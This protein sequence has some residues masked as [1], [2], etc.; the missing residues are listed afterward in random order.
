MIVIDMKKPE[1]CAECPAAYMIRSGEHEGMTMCNVMEYQGRAAEESLVD[2][3][4]VPEGCPMRE[5]KLMP[6]K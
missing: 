6:G 4:T 1:I 2:E 3:Y 5:V